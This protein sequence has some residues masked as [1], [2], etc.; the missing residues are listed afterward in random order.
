VANTSLPIQNVQE[1]TWCVETLECYGLQ[2][3]S[4]YPQTCRTA[5]AGIEIETG[6]SPTN[7]AWQATNS[8]TDCGQ[9]AVVVSDASPGGE[10]D[11]FYNSSSTAVF[12][13]KVVLPDTS[14]DSPSLASLNGN[15]YLAWKGDGSDE[16]NVEYSSNNG[17]SFG[18]KYTSFERVRSRRHCA[19]IMAGFTSRGRAMEMTI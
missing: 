8:V 18:N 3:C 5:M 1:L 7:P 9:H 16:L 2:K 19:H 10:V 11:L 15:L 4:D 17:A 14:P 6:G 13:G 12:N